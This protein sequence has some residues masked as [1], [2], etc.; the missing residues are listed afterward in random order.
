M[1]LISQYAAN[2][3]MSPLLSIQY[4]LEMPSDRM[5][6]ADAAWHCRCLC[7]KLAYEFA[8]II[9]IIQPQCAAVQDPAWK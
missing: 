6:D 3:L 1:I 4:E 8:F 7:E 2:C 9:C 5:R